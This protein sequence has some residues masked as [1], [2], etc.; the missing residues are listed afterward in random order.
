VADHART[1][2]TRDAVLTVVAEAIQ[3]QSCRL[4]DL[5]VELDSGGRNG[6]GLFRRA[7][8]EVAPGAR[9]APEAVAAILLR[10]AKLVGF[11]HNVPITVLGRTVVPDFL[12]LT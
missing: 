9:S 10:R 1:L 11:Q 7:L 2:Q 3:R 6:S 5:Q 8:L 12:W 4:V